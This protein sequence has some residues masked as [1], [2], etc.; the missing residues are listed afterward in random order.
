MRRQELEPQ[1]DVEG[2]PGPD[3]P[4][5]NLGP[6]GHPAGLLWS[7]P[8]SSSKFYFDLCLKISLAAYPFLMTKRSLNK[9]AEL[10]LMTFQTPSAHA[11]RDMDLPSESWHSFLSSNS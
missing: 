6:C 1:K 8:F 2:D 9:L 4:G 11:E 7:V 3:T 5:P 10:G